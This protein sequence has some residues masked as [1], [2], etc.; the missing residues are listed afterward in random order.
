MGNVVYGNQGGLVYANSPTSNLLNTSIVGPVT[1]PD[2]FQDTVVRRRRMENIRW[3][4]FVATGQ[5]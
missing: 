5:W 1:C 2:N 3:T 4:N